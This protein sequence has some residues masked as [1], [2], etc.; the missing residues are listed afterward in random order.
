MLISDYIHSEEWHEYVNHTFRQTQETD[1]QTL[2]GTKPEQ[3]GGVSA[4]GGAGSAVDDDFKSKPVV[5]AKSSV[6]DIDDDNAEKNLNSE[7]VDAY[8]DQF[9]RYLCQ[10]MVKD[11]P[12][13]FMGAD[14]S[15]DEEEKKWIG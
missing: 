14:S 11:L 10:Q 13:R 7:S 3:V 8:H 12:D 4:F 2:G 5:L 15:D 9:T 1:R 6:H